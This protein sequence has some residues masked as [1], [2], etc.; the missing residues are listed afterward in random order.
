MSSLG[1]WCAAAL[2]VVVGASAATWA[3]ATRSANR[4]GPAVADALPQRVDAP[5]LWTPPVGR[6]GGPAAA[7]V[8]GGSTIGLRNPVRGEGTVDLVDA[9]GTG[10]RLLGFDFDGV[11]VPGERLLL[12]ADGT[13]VAYPDGNDILLLDVRDGGTHRLVSNLGVD[14]WYL[15][16]AW[17]PDG[18]QLVAAQDRRGDHDGVGLVDVASGRFT[19]LVPV[20]GGSLRRPVPGYSAAYSR[21]GHHLAIQVDERITLIDDGVPTGS[22]AVPAG[23]RLAGKGAWSPDGRALALVA[24]QRFSSTVSFVDATSGKPTGAAL[25]AQEGVTTQ[26]LL[27]WR[28]D[29]AAVV[30]AYLPEPDVPATFDVR[31]EDDHPTNFAAVRRVELRALTPAGAARTLLSPPDQ[32][33]AIDVADDALASGAVRP[34]GPAPVWPAAPSIAAAAVALLLLPLVGLV[35]LVVLLMRRRRA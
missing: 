4:A 18:R 7:L 27:G 23:S 14:T 2:L 10:H 8:L 16:L 34:G 25:P 15:P 20:T 21:D 9:A 31:D 28:P 32:V 33:L 29:G 6:A 1:R 24:D 3:M 11:N 22:F 13:R 17:S 30:A 19:E 5:W 35:G 12:S 26:R